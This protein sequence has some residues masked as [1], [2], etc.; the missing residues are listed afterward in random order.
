MQTYNCNDYLNVVQ[1]ES[2]IITNQID[3]FYEENKNDENIK[4]LLY[5]NFQEQVEDFRFKY[6][7]TTV[8]L[9][10]NTGLP[11]SFDWECTKKQK[12]IS[13]KL[14]NYIKNLKTD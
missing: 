2:D 4:D 8:A 13:N 9:I 10:D 12:E 7:N 3:S 14:S 6:Q 5:Q 11:V 1:K